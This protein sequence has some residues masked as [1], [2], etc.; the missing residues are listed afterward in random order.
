MEPTTFALTWQ[1]ITLLIWELI[2]KGFALYRAG[3]KQQP[4]WFIFLLILNTAGI[5]PII[6]LIISRDKKQKVIAK[7]K[8]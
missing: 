2:W 7:K 3:R 6:Y 8:R 4:I 1:L 5:L